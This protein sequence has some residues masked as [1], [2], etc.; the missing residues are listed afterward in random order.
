MEPTHAIEHVL[1][2]QAVHAVSYLWLIP[3]LPLVGAAWNAILGWKLQQ[4]LGKKIVHRVAV[5]AMALSFA[6]AVYAFVQLLGLPAHERF[7]QDTLWNLLTAGRL[8][9]DLAFALDP[10]SMMMV[11]IITGIG[12][13]IHVFSIGY[14]ADEPAYWR[15]FSYLNLFVFAMLLLVMGDNFA[16]M[17]FGWEG[18]GLASYLL[19]AFWYTDPEK[20]KA[21]MKAFVVN[22]FGDFGFIAGLFLLFWA[23]GGAWSPREGGGLRSTDYRPAAELNALVGATS[24]ADAAALAPVV[25]GVKVGPTMN[26]RELRDQVV[27]EATGVKEHLATTTVWGVSLA[28]LVGILLFVGAMGKSAQLPLYVWLPDAMAGPTPVSALI[29]AATMVTAGVY[30]VARLN[31]LFALSASAMGWVALVGALTAIFSASIGFFQYDIKKVLAYSTVSQLGFMFIGVGVGAYWAGSYHLLTHAFFKACLFLGSGS[32]ILGC[33]HEQDM[34]KMG[35]LAKH[36]P[37]TRWTYLAACVAIAGFPLMNGFYSKDEILFK[38][39]TSRHLGLFGTPTPWLGPAIYFVGIA[40]AIGTSF[41]MFR[42]YYMTF[43]GEYRGGSG[44]HD[45]HNVDPHSALA[46]RASAHSHDVHADD[47]AAHAFG[48]AGNAPSHGAHELDEPPHASAPHAHGAAAPAHAAHAPHDDHGASHGQHGGTPHESPWTMT[49]VLVVLAAG[50]F[51]TLFLGIPTLW[52]HAAPL[53]E[54]WLEPAIPAEVAFEQAPHAL[55]WAFQGIGV[56]AAAIGLLAARALY[57][58]GRSE[59]PA[60]LKARFEGI[61]TVVYNKY[62]VDEIYDALVVRPSTAFAQLAS[63]F[64]GGVIDGAVNFAGAIGRFLGR[65]DAWIDST[66]VDGAVNLVASLT[67]AAGGGLRRLQT[68]RVQTYLYGALGGALAVVL[69]N[70]LIS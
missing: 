33:H 56:L 50:S 39:F 5:T 67:S 21:G 63:R 58:D 42:S 55:E 13:L 49:S 35:G 45:E 65:F 20:A 6:V 11:L 57:K 9:V 16:V 52:T 34:R 15:F 24:A 68:G 27:V 43:T 51:L 10:L 69:L 41:Y 53:L 64:D 8:T 26:F 40:A 48:L 54:H 2:P 19:I 31:F 66:F 59:V 12:T 70:F 25:E 61:W 18:V 22:R 37:I 38:A 60:R 29:H 28:M 47:G 23:L 46:A 14:M 32:V 44:H 36:M 30:M 3:A 7:L 1:G 62:Y 17:F 4:V